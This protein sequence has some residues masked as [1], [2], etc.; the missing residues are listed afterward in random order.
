MQQIA[1]WLEKPRLPLHVKDNG[2]ISHEGAPSR[3]GT[4]LVQVPA[5]A[6]PPVDVISGATVTT[7]VIGDSITGSAIGIARSRGI[8]TAQAA[9]AAATPAT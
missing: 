6:N 5:A 7:L 8:G 1:D 4:V 3:P 2:R 9:P